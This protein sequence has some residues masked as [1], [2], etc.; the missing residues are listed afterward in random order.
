MG[1]FISSI[2]SGPPKMPSPD[3]GLA[4][5][6][7]ESERKAKEESDTLKAKQDE[8]EAAIRRGRRGR[9]SLISPEGG[10]LGFTG[11]IGG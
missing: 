6:R 1:S 10:E 5:A 11:L 9:R 8:E 4:A 2:F 3:S 7:A